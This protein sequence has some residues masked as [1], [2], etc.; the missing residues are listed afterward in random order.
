ML[1]LCATVV[2]RSSESGEM[3]MSI[4]P[5]PKKNPKYL[6]QENFLLWPSDL[7]TVLG[8]T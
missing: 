5:P 6:N 1:M 2:F 4:L 3:Y 8:L 7:G